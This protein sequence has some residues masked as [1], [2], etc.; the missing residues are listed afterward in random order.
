MLSVTGIMSPPAVT[1]G[2]I[3][4]PVNVGEA[5][6]AFR[7]SS[8]SVAFV[9]YVSSTSND[10]LT[11]FQSIPTPASDDWSTT[12]PK[13]AFDRSVCVTRSAVFAIP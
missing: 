5:F 10:S 11:A 3:T 13:R 4:V 1:A 6:G 8:V 9:I 2:R 7:S 12:A